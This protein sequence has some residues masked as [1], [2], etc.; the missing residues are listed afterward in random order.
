MLLLVIDL[1]KKSNRPP[2]ALAA[3][4]T[5]PGPKIEG[6]RSD[7]KAHPTFPPLLNRTCVVLAL[8][9]ARTSSQRMRSRMRVR[10]PRPKAV[11]KT[12]L[13]PAI[14]RNIVR[15]LPEGAFHEHSTV[16]E[17]RDYEGRWRRTRTVVKCTVCLVTRVRRK[18]TRRPI[19]TSYV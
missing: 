13:Q 15:L 12:I 6:G 3:P 16:R 7:V 17:R 8:I 10:M 1:S 19:L 11:K 9:P 14:R 4:Q 5:M 2:L 18:Y